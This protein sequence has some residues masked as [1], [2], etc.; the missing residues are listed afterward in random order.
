MTGALIQGGAAPD[1]VLAATKS[2][3]MTT[4]A[5]IR[6][7]GKPDTMNPSISSQA[8]KTRVTQR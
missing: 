8:R 4:V 7:G 3:W 5:R 6:I 2:S 1:Q